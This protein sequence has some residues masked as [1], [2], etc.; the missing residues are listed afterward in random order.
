MYYKQMHTQGGEWEVIE[1]ISK[2]L[3]HIRGAIFAQAFIIKS[4]NL[5][6]LS[7]LMVAPENGDTVLK[8]NLQCNQ[9]GDS[10]NR[11]ITPINII[12]HKEIIRVWKA[13]YNNNNDISTKNKT[14]T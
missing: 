13:A 7:R 3:P 2:V 4:I 14:T 11:I 12:A 1:E 8:A 5:S 6:N 9:Q 10:F